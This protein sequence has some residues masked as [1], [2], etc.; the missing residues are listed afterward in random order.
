MRTIAKAAAYFLLFILASV[1]AV[2]YT[3]PVNRINMRS[4]LMM[5][6]DFNDDGKWDLTDDAALDAITADPFRMP[7]AT[8]Y[9]A[10][11]NHNGLLDEEDIYFLR[12]L[13]KTGDPYRAR[14]HFTAA[15]HAF[16]YPREF[17]RYVPDTE[18]I[19]HPVLAIEHKAEAGSPL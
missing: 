18:Y 14:E 6:G 7:A 5:L 3:L 9:K 19:Q 2:Y 13:Y 12:E 16:P 15:R 4:E 17:F 8:V 1:A 11:V 10:D